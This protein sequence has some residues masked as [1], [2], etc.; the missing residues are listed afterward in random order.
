MRWGRLH[1]FA[2]DCI[3]YAADRLEF[4]AFT[5][6]DSDQLLLRRGYSSFIADALHRRPRVGLLGKSCEPCK[7]DTAVHPAQAALAEADLWRPLLARFPETAAR[8]ADWTTVF[9]TLWPSTVLS[10]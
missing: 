8:F 6:V 7:L 3:R 10:P 1:D 5:I 4:D 9:W 2:F